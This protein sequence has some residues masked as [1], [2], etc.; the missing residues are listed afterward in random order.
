[1]ANK[2]FFS[3]LTF[4]TLFLIINIRLLSAEK[5]SHIN[6]QTASGSLNS[7]PDDIECVVQSFY[8]HRPDG[9]P[10]RELILNFKGSKFSGKG[11][12]E[13]Y[14]SGDKETILLDVN[15]AIDKLSV[16]LPPGVGV[17]SDAASANRFGLEQ[18]QPLAKR[19]ILDFAQLPIKRKSLN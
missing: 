17:K 11:T 6:S 2:I 8:R 12:I 19:H 16:L 9:R 3:I 7:F 14:C 18:A 10:G 4:S 1:M 13:L 15:D 5:S